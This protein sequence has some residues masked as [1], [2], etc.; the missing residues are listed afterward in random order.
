MLF[1]LADTNND[2]QISQK[3]AIDAG[4]LMVGGFFFRADQNGDGVL[5]RT[6]RS[7]PARRCFAQQP[8]LRYVV[9]QGQ[10]RGR[11]DA[12][13]AGQRRPGRR[14]R[15]RPSWQPARHQQRQADPGDRGAPGGPDGRPGAVRRGRH[16]PRR[17]AQPDR[18][19]RGD[20]RRGPDGGPGRLPAR[21]TPTTTASSAGPSSTRRSSSRRN[22]VFAILD[23]NNDGQ[24]SPQEAQ[25]AR[26][27]DRQ[28][29]QDAAWSP[30]RPT[31][32]RNLIRSGRRADQVAPVPSS[33]P[34]APAATHRP[35][36]RRRRIRRRAR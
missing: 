23:A 27:V 11:T 15:R 29:A 3:E 1:K 6:R 12:T 35:S 34:P 18:D 20:H 28:P 2:G 26:Q 7:R 16:Q 17:P 9:E 13:R 30:S 8:L 5:S 24:I 32:P 25:Q 31:R 21:P 14:T 4:N 33:A 36:S 22:V 10:G 19:Q